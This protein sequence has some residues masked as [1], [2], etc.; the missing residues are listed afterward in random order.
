MGEEIDIFPNFFCYLVLKRFS[1]FG[2]REKGTLC[3]V[4]QRGKFFDLR[5]ER[6]RAILTSTL[7]TTST[8][9]SFST[10]LSLSNLLFIIVCLYVSLMFFLSLT[11]CRFVSNLLPHLFTNKCIENTLHPPKYEH[12]EWLPKLE[13]C[14]GTRFSTC[15]VVFFMARSGF[16]FI[17]SWSFIG[18]CID[19]DKTTRMISKEEYLKERM[20]IR[21]NCERH[22]IL[23][24]R[25][26]KWKHNWKHIMEE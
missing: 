19:G 20:L 23:E 24:K 6:G 12:D 2:R 17:H 25:K 5:A 11:Y 1:L 16:F 7:L 18:R 9:I 8:C 26:K 14:W 3:D 15:F 4:E 10:F 13:K 21:D 22:E